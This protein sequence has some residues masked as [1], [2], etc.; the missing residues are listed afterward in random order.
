MVMNFY[1]SGLRDFQFLIRDGF[2][3]PSEVDCIRRIVQMC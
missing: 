1:A 2:D 3:L